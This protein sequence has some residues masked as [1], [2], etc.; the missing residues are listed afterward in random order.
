MPATRR[1]MAPAASP[2][3]TITDNVPPPVTPGT[4]V[5]ALKAELEKKD[6]EN[7]A[8]R[9][10]I[11][12]LTNALSG[13]NV[14]KDKIDTYDGSVVAAQAPKSKR[15]K[16]APVPS[17]TAYKF[18][19]DAH[20][21]TKE[22]VN[23][24]QVWKECSPE[25]RQSY[26]AMA[27][28]DKAR[29]LRELATY[30]EEKEA[31]EE[32]Y[33]KKKQD[34]AMEFFD[35]HLAAQAV[36]EKVDAE[37]KK[38]KKNATKKDPEAPKRPLSS[39]MYFVS[40]MRESVT[41]KNSNMAPTEIIKTL[42][43]MWGELKKGT[44]KGTKKYDDLAAEDRTRYEG[45][46]K[47]Y[48][49]MVEE[50]NNQLDQEKLERL[51]QD[52]EE[53]MKLLKSRQ[54]AASVSASVMAARSE[55]MKMVSLDDMSVVSELTNINN[56]PKK[57][58]KVK[59]PNAPKGK[60]SAYIYF[61]CENRNQVKASMPEGTTQ[62]ELLTEIGRQWKDLTEEKKEKYVEMANKDKERY[63]EEMEKYTAA[64]K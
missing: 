51:S 26:D 37:N 46:K 21:K 57:V 10:S 30:Q 6:A 5:V 23:M 40:D 19:C 53:A 43:E 49:A 39:Y 44:K 58:K 38:G 61:T 31:L 2:L 1:S 9:N 32:Y 8:L 14:V 64:K 55:A 29:Y 36:L 15:D 41:K 3:K 60:S 47:V 11:A 17:K 27:K 52:K 63:D 25:I 18:W 54:D 13:L 24:Q 20:P 48:D 22:G 42:G 12:E 16:D 28:A 45:E 7:E 34:M 50:R 62:K 33:G 35:A 4:K 59:D 56:K